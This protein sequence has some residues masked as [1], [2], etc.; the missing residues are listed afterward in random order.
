MYPNSSYSKNLSESV[1]QQKDNR[2]VV[3][4]YPLQDTIMTPPIFINQS[5]IVNYGTSIARLRSD[6]KSILWRVE[7]PLP[8]HTLKKGDE[9]DQTDLLQTLV[10]L[11]YAREEICEEFGK[12]SVKGGVVDVYSPLS[13]D[14]VRLDFFGDT[15]ESIK[16][17]DSSTQRS[18]SELEK[19]SILPVN[20][21]LLSK[22][23]WELYQK[24][25][26]LR[27]K[28]LK[29]PDLEISH[30]T[31]LEELVPVIH[32]PHGLLDYFKTPPMI[33][34]HRQNE[35]VDKVIQIEREYKSLYE[36]RKIYIICLE[37]ETLLSFQK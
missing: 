24:E 31:A 22:K 18:I 6:S 37:P 27:G 8:Y 21:F 36:K 14:P 29:K 10:A 7:T 34:F 17:F 20:E 3:Q 32:E 25:I 28:G 16:S 33:L 4:S 2:V 35:L 26:D 23:E 9:I 30:H 1:F 15:L 11:G 12:F 5:L 13:L 19:I